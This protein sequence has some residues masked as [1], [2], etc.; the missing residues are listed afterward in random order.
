MSHCCL[1]YHM[2]FS[3][4]ERR[5]LLD[6]EVMPRLASYI[7]GT[8]RGL[9]GTLL[10]ANGPEDHIH[11]S[12]IL[13]PVHAVADMMRDIKSSST[14]WLRREVPGMK[15]FAWQDGYAAFSVS[16]SVMPAVLNYIRS[17]QDHH[18]KMTFVE[19]LTE[20][21]ERHGVAFDPAYL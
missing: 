18:R 19:E 9:G 3:T 8:I 5:P 7:G 11:I 14:A 4:K 10:E 15:A 20:L 13:P 16:Q 17:Q 21:L 2:A 6:P 12:A 1:Q